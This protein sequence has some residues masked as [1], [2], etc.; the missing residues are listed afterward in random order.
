MRTKDYIKI[1]NKLAK[2]LTPEQKISF[3]NILYGE[4]G[5]EIG[6]DNHGQEIIYTGITNCKGCDK[7]R[8]MNDEE[9]D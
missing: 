1:A 6:T 4:F 9:F 3:G 7:Y 8:Y 5:G 2:K